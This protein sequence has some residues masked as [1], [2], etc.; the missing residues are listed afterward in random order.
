M[1]KLAFHFK[2]MQNSITNLL[3][4]RFLIQ[5]YIEVELIYIEHLKKKDG[6]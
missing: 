3:K 6:K 1:G 2:L 4:N 5:D